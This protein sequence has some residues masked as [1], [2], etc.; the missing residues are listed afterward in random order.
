M[1]NIGQ[2]LGFSLVHQQNLVYVTC[3]EDPR[4]DRV[5]LN[6][7]TDDTVLVITSAG[8]NAL[9]YAL[10]EPK[11]I[12]AVDVNPKQNA[13]LE[14][15]I[16]AIRELDF[17][18]FFQ[19]FGRGK[20]K[21][22]DE[23]YTQKLRSH[24]SSISQAYW[25]K[26]G[27]KFFDSD[28]SFYF[29]GTTGNFALAINYYID[30]IV[31]I[32]PSI[33]AILNAKTSQEQQE[34]YHCEIEQAFWQDWLYY[35]LNSDFVLWMLGI[36]LQQRQ[37]MELYLEGSIATFIR[38]R[39]EQVFTE[40]PIQDNYFWRVFLKGEYRRDCCPEYLK[41][42]NFERLKSGLVDCIQVKTNTVTNFLE[43]CQE[44]IS[45][46]VLLDHMDW[47]SRS[48][49]EQLQQEWQAILDRASEKTRILFRSGALQVEYLDALPVVYEGKEQLLQN[50]L[51]YDTE[52]A[53]QLHPQ[54]RVQTYGSFYIADLVE[55]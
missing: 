31:K 37:Q 39:C 50:L 48:S 51:R 21:Q 35:L 4:L 24:L 55:A 23:I 8:C 14:L 20:L 19:L 47:L 32:R 43:N 27:T 49:H 9:E 46:F 41:E 22:F 15:K 29:R 42:E 30:H 45:R 16:A 6:L 2:D 34:I 10:D 11:Q 25:D 54:D 26:Q 17:E 44:K 18:H 1:K 12:Y 53:E 38:Q 36:P 7:Q 52:L 40:I 5:A 13:L 33:D 3:W 28:R